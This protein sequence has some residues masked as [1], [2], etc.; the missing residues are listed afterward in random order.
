MNRLVKKSN[1]LSHHKI[2]HFILYYFFTIT[3]KSGT[4]FVLVIRKDV[5]W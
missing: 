3:L 5:Y 1:N 4:Y 2:K